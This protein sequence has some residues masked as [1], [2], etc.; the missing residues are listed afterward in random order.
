MHKLEPNEK[1]RDEIEQ[2][3][4]GQIDSNRQYPS[5]FIKQNF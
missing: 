2:P 3:I 4:I 5:L 1:K